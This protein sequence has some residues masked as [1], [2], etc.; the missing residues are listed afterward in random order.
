MRSLLIDAMRRHGGVLRRDVAIEICPPHV[1]D[2]AVRSAAIVVAHPGVYRLPEATDIRAL[3]RAALAYCPAGALS[4]TDALDEWRLPSMES[5]R[6]HVTVGG[7]SYP[8]SSPGVRLHRRRGFVAEPP[9][10][11]ERDGLRVVRLE[12]AVVES[13]GLL[14]QLARR[15]PAIVAVRERR[16]TP[17]RLTD[18]LDQQPRTPGAR[19]QRKLFTLLAAGNHSELEIWGHDRVFS[20]QRLPRSVTQHRV[21]AG[22]RVVLLDRAFLEEMVAVELD[23][24]AYHGS[25]GQREQ[26]VRR[27]SAVA[28]LGWLTVRYT[29]PR[30]HTDPGGVV[31]ELLDILERR[32]A[33]LRRVG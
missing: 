23:G 17:R 14:P 4:H 12:Q 24:A 10:T 21:Q 9:A 31:E 7:D 30:L 5:A 22:S 20:D 16:T 29:H 18:V 28:R 19:E 3:R 26:D 1:V 27:D 13:W 2:D 6:V 8:V 25:P 33:Q 11:R 32:R 15:A